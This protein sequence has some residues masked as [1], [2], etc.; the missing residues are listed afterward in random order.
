VETAITLEC[1]DFGE[2]EDSGVADVERASKTV[3]NLTFLE[4]WRVG[5]R[6]VFGRLV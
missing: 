2:F 4:K 1:S 5:L 3:R 6:G